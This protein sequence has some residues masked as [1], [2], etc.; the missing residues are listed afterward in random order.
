MNVKNPMVEKKSNFLKTLLEHLPQKIFFKD[1]N[2]VYVYCN[3]LLAEDLG[4]REEEVAG[5]TDDDFFSWEL[6]E[7]YRRDDRRILADLT[8]EDIAETDF[9]PGQF[10]MLRVADKGM[11]ME[12]R[13]LKRIFDPF[14]TTK[15][16]GKGTGMGL[17]TV[18]GIVKQ[19]KGYIRAES[20][21][22]EGAVFTVYFPAEGV[23]S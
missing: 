8:T 3:G 10:V 22:G 4:M 11:G 6:A 15:K 5:K 2:S 19:N 14:F 17:S 7:K 12:R 16:A 13:I 21:P 9:Q 1:L 20:E 18:Y 23:T